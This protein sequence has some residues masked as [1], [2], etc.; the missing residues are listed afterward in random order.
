MKAIIKTSLTKSR[1]KCE[2]NLFP[3]ANSKNFSGNKTKKKAITL[4]ANQNTYLNL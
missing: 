3:T 1:D 2:T 4:I